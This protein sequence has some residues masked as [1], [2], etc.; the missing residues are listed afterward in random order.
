M[1]STGVQGLCTWCR[2]QEAHLAGDDVST[3]QQA[4]PAAEA[5][6][7][8]LLGVLRRVAPQQP[9][10]P[11]EVLIAISNYNLVLSGQ[12]PLWLQV[13][14]LSARPAPDRCPCAAFA[15]CP[16]AWTRTLSA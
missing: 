8:E 9:G 12:L 10:R 3:C 2:G 14:P 7:G 4:G 1:A 5:K 16:D 11:K 15:V 6:G 13:S